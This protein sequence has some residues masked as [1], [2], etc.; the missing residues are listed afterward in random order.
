MT[1]HGLFNSAVRMPEPKTLGLDRLYLERSLHNGLYH[2]TDVDGYLDKALRSMLVRTEGPVLEVG[3]GTGKFAHY[4]STLTDRQVCG[5]DIDQNAI[6]VANQEYGNVRNLRFNVGNVYDLNKN[7]SEVGLVSTMM[8]LHHFDDLGEAMNQITGVLN[9]GGFVLIHDWERGLALPDIE[10]CGLERP[11]M[12]ELYGAHAASE[13]TVNETIRKNGLSDDPSILTFFS[14]LAAYTKKEVVKALDRLGFY[15]ETTMV[16]GDA[17]FYLAAYRANPLKRT[18]HGLCD[19][20]YDTVGSRITDYWIAHHGFTTGT[21]IDI[22]KELGLK[23]P[24]VN[25]KEK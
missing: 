7:F 11:V 8:S 24:L 18:I 17:K 25:F 2:G 1:N 9:P 12:D 21:R 5:I 22:E 20:L 15:S 23:P 14:V 16:L 4:L 13:Q 3:C 19:A 10:N 6:A